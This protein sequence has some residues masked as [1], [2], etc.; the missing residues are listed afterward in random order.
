MSIIKTNTLSTLDGSYSVPSE[1]LARGACRAWVNFDGTGTVAIR[2]S[3]NV[4]SVTR[5]GAGTYVVNLTTALPDANGVA[6]ITVIPGTA[7]AANNNRYVNGAVI[8][9]D[10]VRVNTLSLNPVNAFND[11]EFIA[12]SVFR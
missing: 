9:T 5:G 11:T 2:A 6:N 7:S 8:A 10:Q 12:V 1:T 3:F 4:S